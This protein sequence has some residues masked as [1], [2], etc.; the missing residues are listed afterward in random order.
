MTIIYMYAIG[1]TFYPSETLYKIF[2][3]Q[4][5]SCEG[6]QGRGGAELAVKSPKTQKQHRHQRGRKLLAFYKTDTGWQHIIT[7]TP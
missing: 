5:L 4:I 1:G 7:A 3:K 6:V 2:L